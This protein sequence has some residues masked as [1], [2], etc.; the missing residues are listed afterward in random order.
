MN[1]T[2]SNAAEQAEQF[3]T[4]IRSLRIEKGFSQGDIAS[5]LGVT[6]ATISNLEQGKNG[7]STDLAV[8]IAEF[9]GMTVN[10]LWTK[11]FVLVAKPD[12]EPA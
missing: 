4:N 2:L 9:F 1:G 7:P 10:D 6:K 3:G 8:R 11:N 12:G 5:V